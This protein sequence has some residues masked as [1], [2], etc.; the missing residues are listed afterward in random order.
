WLLLRTDDYA[1]IDAT[2]RIDARDIVSNVMESQA[3]GSPLVLEDAV[4]GFPADIGV[5]TSDGHQVASLG[6]GLAPAD[7]VRTVREH[8]RTA[9]EWTGNVRS[10]SVDERVVLM[11]VPASQDLVLVTHP[12]TEQESNLGSTAMLL[13]EVVAGLVVLASGLGYLLAERALA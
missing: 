2:L 1:T 9:A 10:R 8:G 5:L 12:L 3:G 7:A 11:R 4:G 6:P 13:A